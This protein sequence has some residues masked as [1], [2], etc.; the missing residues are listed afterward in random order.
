[1]ASVDGTPAAVRTF[2]DLVEL[3]A[4]ADVLGPVPLPPGVR[5]PAG[6]RTDPMPPG[7]AYER[8]LIR[9][10][11]RHGRDLARALSSAQA[12]RVGGNDAGPLR[13]QVDPPTIG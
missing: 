13:V 8:L 3:P 2:V 11:R 7:D 4:G 1:M 5:G 12:R 6:G 10:D 9:V